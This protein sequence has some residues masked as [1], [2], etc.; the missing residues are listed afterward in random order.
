MPLFALICSDKPG[1]QALRLENRAAHLAYL[2]ASG[3]VV[4]A[5]P[6][7]DAE[8]AM[9]GSLVVLDLPDRAAARAW[10]DADPYAQAGLFADVRIETWKKVIG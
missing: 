8:G 7:L 4:H 5:G 3:C 9:S 1:Q 10:A 2:Q 6:F